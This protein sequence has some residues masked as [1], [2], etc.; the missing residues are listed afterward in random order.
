MESTY[1]CTSRK[2]ISLLRYIK[3]T[4]TFSWGGG[5]DLDV[6]SS[7][8]SAVPYQLYFISALNQKRFDKVIYMKVFLCTLR[9]TSN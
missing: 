4:I 2:N 9:L 7:F 5:G 1:E 3:K 6:F 8:S